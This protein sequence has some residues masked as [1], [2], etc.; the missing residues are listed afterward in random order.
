MKITGMNQNVGTGYGNMDANREAAIRQQ[1]Q[2]LKREISQL[3]Q[4]QE[5]TKAEQERKRQLE[6]RIR[7]L[8]QKLATVN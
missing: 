7:E 2:N 4:K 3:E 1:L 8:E 6:R 5:L